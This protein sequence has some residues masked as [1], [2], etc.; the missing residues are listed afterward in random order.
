MGIILKGKM[1]K[2]IFKIRS[3]DAFLSLHVEV[4]EGLVVLRINLVYSII[5]ILLIVID[6]RKLIFLG[7][8]LSYD[9][10][11]PTSG[12]SLPELLFKWGCRLIN[13]RIVVKILINTLL[14]CCRELLVIFD[15]LEWLIHILLWY[16]I[17]L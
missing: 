4:L 14:I 10:S 2:F 7:I 11:H 3:W 8:T 12:I 15:W 17:W 6:F 13:L 1:I 9:R 16:L 5:E